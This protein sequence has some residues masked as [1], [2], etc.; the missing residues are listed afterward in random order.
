MGS[1]WALDAMMHHFKVLLFW[2]FKRLL[3]TRQMTPNVQCVHHPCVLMCCCDPAFSVF[4]CAD[5]VGI[6]VCQAGNLNRGHFRSRQ[7]RL[8]VHYHATHVSTVSEV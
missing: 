5:T 6:Y 3:L 1:T 7:G 2:H 8:P 4:S